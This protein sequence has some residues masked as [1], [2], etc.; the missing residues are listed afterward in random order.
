MVV[1]GT[2]P[3]FRPEA[4]EAQRQQWLGRVQLARPLALGWITAGVVCTAIAIGAFLS[5]AHY[6]RKATVSGVL[7]PDRGL[8]RLVPADAGTV[9]ERRVAVGQNVQAGQTLFTLA[10]ARQLLA[11]PVQSQVRHSLD[12]RRS[13]LAAAV[14]S[15]QS[16]ERTRLAALDRRLEALAIELG[17]LDAEAALQ[18]QRIGLAQQAQARLQ[19]LQADHFISAAQVQ[20][21][22]EELLGLEAAAQSLARQKAALQRDRAEIE[23]ERRALPLVTG[24]TVGGIERDLAQAD[25]EAAEQDADRHL[26]VRAPQA[27]TVASVL[28]DVGQSVSP[29]SALA[30]IVPAGA[31]LQAQLYAPGSAVGFVQAGQSVRMRYEAFPYQKYGQQRG[32]VLDVS[33]VPLGAAELAALAL[34]AA[35]GSGEPLFLITVALDRPAETMPLA[36]GMRLQADV[37]LERRRLVEWLFEPLLGLR[38]RL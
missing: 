11:D 2:R 22:S 21:K 34:P 1:T 37:V 35:G 6:T 30:T 4:V 10:L 23:G 15:Q 25:R 16:L 12:E 18:Q 26:L 28:A 29:A 19:Q 17:R 24:S 5:L 9:V 3:L 14:Q 8:I 20:T 31:Q 32:H 13:S 27:G 38:R 7:A 33:R 36:A